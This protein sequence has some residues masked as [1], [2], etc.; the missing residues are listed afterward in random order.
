MLG[1]LFLLEWKYAS[2]RSRH[3]RFRAG[4]CALVLAEFL[5]CM[6]AWATRYLD[7]FKGNLTPW[8]V[9]ASIINTYLPLFTLQTF[10]LLVAVTPALAAGSVSD[11]KARGTFTLLLITRLRSWEIVIAKWLGQTGHVLVMALPVLPFVAFLQGMA[12]MPLE[13]VAVWLAE[14]AVLTMLFAAVSLLASVLVRRTLTAM[15]VAYTLLLAVPA[16]ASWAGFGFLEHLSWMSSP[17][18]LASPEWQ[19]LMLVAA[20]LSALSLA[21]AAWRLR[22]AC[23]AEERPVRVR[24]WTWWRQRPPV[25][26]P[27]MRWKER[28]VGEL[29]VFAIARRAPRWVWLVLLPAAGIAVSFAHAKDDTFLAHGVA[30]IVVFGLFVTLRSSGAISRERERQTW[31]GLLLTPLEPYALI[32]GKLW[33]IMDS[34]TPY[35]LAYFLGALLWSVGF[36]VDR[37]WHHEYWIGVWAVA[38]TVVC[39]LSAWGFVYF[40]TANGLYHSAHSPNTLR[41]TVQ[42]IWTGGTAVLTGAAVPVVLMV[43]L[44]SPVVVLLGSMPYVLGLILALVALICMLMLSR[45]EFLLQQAEQHIADQER[46]VQGRGRWGH[47]IYRLEQPTG[48]AGR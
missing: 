5:F 15:L 26:D 17:V 10:V 7:P 20:V 16:A 27:P 19:W 1:P 28:Y 29:G 4:Y 30:M 33:G 34:I 40:Q 8:R 36:C 47:T 41:A 11:E 38:C 9:N 21:V 14:C 6:F 44:V 48:I 18:R 13:Y 25:S 31:E 45:A 39:W 2:R 42:A 23:L 24:R 22:P 43:C 46:I 12:G 35:L 3:F 32:R 37:F